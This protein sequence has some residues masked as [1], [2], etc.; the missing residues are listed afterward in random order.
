MFKLS[1][2]TILIV[3]DDE[4]AIQLV[5]Q[6][7]ASCPGDLHLAVVPNS[8]A[9][10]EWLSAETDLG[11]HIPRLILID[12]KLPK[13]IGLAV[14]RTLR[15]DSRLQNVPIV[16]YSEVSEPSDV[17]LAY[18]IGA[19]SFVKKPESLSEFSQLLHDLIDLGWTSEK[20]IGIT[21]K[22]SVTP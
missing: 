20:G 22:Q 3:E 2:D 15:L 4:F 8:V 12:L 9:A 21:L 10:M 17:V 14:V 5:Q 16:V 13:L 1:G 6:A 7:L 18:Q 19:N 11:H